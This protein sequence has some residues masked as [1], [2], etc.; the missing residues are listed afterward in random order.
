MSNI[1]VAYYSDADFLNQIDDQSYVNTVNNQTV[2]VVATNTITQCSNQAEVLL[3]VNTE[4]SQSVTLEACDSLDETGLVSFDLMVA[5]TVIYANEGFDKEVEGFYE[6][7]NDALLLQ[8]P[9]NTNYTNNQPYYQVIYAR[10][11]QDGNCH[12]I[13]EVML[14]VKPLPELLEDETVFYCLNTFPETISLY[15]GIVNDVPNNYYYNWSTGETT[16]NIDVNEPGTYTVDVTRPNGCTNQRVI[17]VLASN[18][19]MIETIEIT[20]I[21]ENNTITILTTGEGE[22]L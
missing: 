5:E 21:S 19:A 6:T 18:T 22:Y 20:D 10:V 11:H 3:V 2:F 16:I 12:S 15:G 13:V 7:Y 9:L 8:N 4:L 1:E 17:T 14:N